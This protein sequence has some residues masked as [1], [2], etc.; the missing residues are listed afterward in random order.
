MVLLN[1]VLNMEESGKLLDKLVRSFAEWWTNGCAYVLLI[2]KCELKP[3]M[4]LIFVIAIY[5]YCC[6]TELF[7]GL[8]KINFLNETEL[9]KKKS[10]TR[11]SCN[12]NRFPQ[13]E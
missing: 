5:Y 13:Y 7:T 3:K 1:T 6:P 10:R 2:R 4:D 11:G 8:N 12:K 9:I